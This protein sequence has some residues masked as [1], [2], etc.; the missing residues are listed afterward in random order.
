M[1]RNWSVSRIAKRG[2]EL[3]IGV[4]KDEEGMAAKGGAFCCIRAGKGTLNV[5][6]ML[7]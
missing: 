5:A 7:F 6:R 4:W 3:R 1:L 2:R